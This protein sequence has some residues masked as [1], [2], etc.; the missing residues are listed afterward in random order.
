MIHV[1][2]VWYP[3]K[4]G[5]KWMFGIREEEEVLPLPATAVPGAGGA[6]ASVW[7]GMTREEW[8]NRLDKRARDGGRC[9]AR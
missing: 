3:V 4:A 8:E 9:N 2:A 7:Q 6:L 5:V 1:I